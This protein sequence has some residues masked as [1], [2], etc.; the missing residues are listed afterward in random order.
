MIGSEVQWSKVNEFEAWW[1]NVWKWPEV[2]NG[3][4]SEVKWTD[5]KRDD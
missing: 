1:L 2:K 3:E 5:L 4:R